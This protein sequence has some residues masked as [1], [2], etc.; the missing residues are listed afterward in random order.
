MPVAAFGPLAA[1][2]IATK[3]AVALTD[4]VVAATKLIVVAMGE[5]LA[6]IF[7]EARIPPLS[8][9]AFKERFATPEFCVVHE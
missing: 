9:D 8:F 2:T 1:N 5:E 3:V 6:E 4:K 7:T